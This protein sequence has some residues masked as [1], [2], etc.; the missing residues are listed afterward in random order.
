MDHFSFYVVLIYSFD[1][2]FCSQRFGHISQ[3]RI[4]FDSYP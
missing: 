1:N 4:K 3:T 2:I